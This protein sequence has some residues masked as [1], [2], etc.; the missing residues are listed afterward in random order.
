MVNYTDENGKTILLGKEI[1]QGGEGIVYECSTDSSLVVKI[2]KKNKLSAQKARKLEVMCKLYDSEIAK[3]SAWVKK[4]VYENNKPV[5]FLM[6]KISDYKQ[7]HLLYGTTEDR[8]KYFPNAEWKFMVHAALNLAI[9]VG[10]LHEK[11]IVIGDINQSNILVNDRA[12]IKLIDCDSYQVAD[13][14]KTFICEV[15]VPEYTSPELQGCSFKNVIRN[16]NHDCFGLAVMIFKTLMFAKHPYSGVNAP[17]EIENAITGNY[18]CYA[19]KYPYQ[20]KPYSI[21]VKTLLNENIIS[22]FEKAFTKSQ[23]RPTAEDWVNALIDFEKDIISCPN[24][25]KHFYNKNASKCIWCSLEKNGINYFKEKPTVQ[26]FNN[27]INNTNNNIN[28]TAKYL[29][30]TKQNTT[31]P[32]SSDEK[33]GCFVVLLIIG[34]IL[35]LFNMFGHSS[36]DTNEQPQVPSNISQQQSNTENLNQTTNTPKNTNTQDNTYN[37]DNHNYHYQYVYQKQ[38]QDESYENNNENEN[39]YQEEPKQNQYKETE[40]IKNVQPQSN[41]QVQ[42]TVQKPIQKEQ[43]Q[44]QAQTK[45]QVQQTSNSTVKKETNKEQEKIQ[46]QP[47][48]QVEKVD[49]DKI[50]KDNED[51]L[52]E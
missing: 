16:Q 34:V 37:N 26:Y 27:N 20:T 17:S 49:Y 39:Y 19:R 30:A 25:K 43:T 31:Q 12:E 23:N 38:Y 5:G 41:I 29:N 36:K 40:Q 50:L 22:L 8:Q 45:I 13:N 51:Y 18:F 21:L 44:T 47:K 32:L 10:T 28:P 3:F 35:F 2:Y 24:D 33:L 7:I 48:S 9:A 15:G 1:A 11:G 46:S 6:E 42:K 52:F 14:G 4:V